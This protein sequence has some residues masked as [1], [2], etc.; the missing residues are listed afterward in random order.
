MITCVLWDIESR[1]LD[2]RPRWPKAKRAEGPSGL[3]TSETILD[4]FKEVTE[5]YFP[6]LLRACHQLA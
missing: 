5:H 4:S 2:R 6:F 1:E 3:A